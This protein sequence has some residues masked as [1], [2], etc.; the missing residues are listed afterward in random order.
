[1]RGFDK[2]TTI[3]GSMLNRL[4]T[5]GIKPEACALFPNWVEL[6]RIYPLNEESSLRREWGSQKKM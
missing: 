2:V 3:S 4:A 1:M 6:D 5:K